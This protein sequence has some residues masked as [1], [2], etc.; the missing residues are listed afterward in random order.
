M[1]SVKHRRC[2]SAA[3]SKVVRLLNALRP[4]TKATPKQQHLSNSLPKAFR[5]RRGERE[6][7]HA[8]PVGSKNAERHIEQA[9]ARLTGSGRLMHGT[10]GPLRR[11]PADCRI[12]RRSPH[13]CSHVVQHKLTNALNSMKI[14]EMSLDNAKNFL[15]GTPAPAAP[16]SPGPPAPDPGTPPATIIPVGSGHTV[17]TQRSRRYP[18]EKDVRHRFRNFVAATIV[19]SLYVRSLLATPL[20]RIA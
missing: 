15:R 4:A 7:D 5:R 16:P 6:M 20:R 11:S 19:R 10:Q 14:G 8:I 3:S 18:N 2:F 9:A 17:G 13:V 12:W 1:F